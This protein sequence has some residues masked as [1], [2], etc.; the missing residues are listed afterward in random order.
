MSIKRTIKRNLVK[1][2]QGNNRI[3]KL[4]EQIR[5]RTVGDKRYEVDYV[6][7]DPKGRH[8]DTLF[9]RDGCVIR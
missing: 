2:E 5:R 3:A 4:W 8:K 1:R 7:C 9:D 6:R